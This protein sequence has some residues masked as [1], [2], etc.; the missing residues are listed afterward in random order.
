[1]N[2][3]VLVLQDINGANYC[4]NVIDRGKMYVIRL[5]N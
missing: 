1:M 2:M 3:D 4:Q 5:L